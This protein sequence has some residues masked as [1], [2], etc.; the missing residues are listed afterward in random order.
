MADVLHSTRITTSNHE[1]KHI[2]TASPIQNGEIITPSATENGKSVLRR[3]TPNDITS[4][5]G[6]SGMGSTLTTQ[7]DDVSTAQTL[8]FRAPHAV[9]SIS[10]VMQCT[11][12]L[13]GAAGVL[14][15]T[16]GAQSATAPIPIGGAAPTVVILLSLSPDEPLGQ[17]I[18][19]ATDGATTNVSVGVFTMRITRP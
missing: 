2:P 7:L 18:T 8:Y 10:V 6:I 15:L 13:A 4:G 5:F 14:T 9:H 19:I 11:V 17:T 16:C 12:V 3:L 1:P